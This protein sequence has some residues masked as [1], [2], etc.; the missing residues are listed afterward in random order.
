[1][2]AYGSSGQL[3]AIAYEPNVGCFFDG[4]DPLELM[5]R[6]PK[7]VAFHVAA[8]EGQSPFSDLDPF[9]CNLRLLAISA[10]TD[11][12]LATV[13]R[14]VPDQVRI[15]ELPPNSSPA[16]PKPEGGDDDAIALAHAIVDEQAQVLRISRSPES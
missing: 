5:R 2:A 15:V 4:D 8:R 16:G 12:E 11:V 6:T 9:S 3:F 7:L 13:F 14:L 1:M 10:A